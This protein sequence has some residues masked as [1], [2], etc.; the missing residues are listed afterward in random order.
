MTHKE[1]SASKPKRAATENEDKLSRDSS[2]QSGTFASTHKERKTVR[3]NTVT[4]ATTEKEMKRTKAT[5][6]NFKEWNFCY[7][8][9]KPGSKQA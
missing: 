6:R 8:E 4:R 1:E 3:K 2:V 7:N 9:L 5:R